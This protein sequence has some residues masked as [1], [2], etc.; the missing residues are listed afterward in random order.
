VELKPEELYELYCGVRAD[1]GLAPVHW[2]SLSA[3]AQQVWTTM[4]S[5][6]VVRQ[7]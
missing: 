5:L 7:P 1:N 4:A 3:A 2:S 6:V